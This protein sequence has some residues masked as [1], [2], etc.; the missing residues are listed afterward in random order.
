MS[1][2]GGDESDSQKA[3]QKLWD[4]AHEHYRSQGI[5]FGQL[6]RKLAAKQ[7]E[8]LTPLQGRE[9]FHELCGAGCTPEVLGVILFLIRIAS[10]VEDFWT[11]MVGGPRP[12]PQSDAHPRECGPRARSLFRTDDRRQ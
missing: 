11:F 4:F 2:P 3:I 7:V 8:Q 12:T 9:D 1:E 6:L 10:D 5:D